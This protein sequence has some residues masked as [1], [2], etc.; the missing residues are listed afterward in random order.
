MNA[1]AQNMGSITEDCRFEKSLVP[2]PWS[3]RVM[4]QQP[5]VST[6]FQKIDLQDMPVEEAY[7]EAVEAHRTAMEEWKAENPEWEPADPNWVAPGMQAS[8]DAAA[9][10]A[11]ETAEP[12]AEAAEPAADAPADAEGE[13]SGS[14]N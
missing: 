4:G 1:E 8:S 14:T 13:T 5:V 10:P 6:L 2:M 12:A 9:E 11:P 7:Q 3:S